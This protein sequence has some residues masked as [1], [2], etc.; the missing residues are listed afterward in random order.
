MR[1]LKVWLSTAG[2]PATIENSFISPPALPWLIFTTDDTYRGTDSENVIVERAVS[3]ELYTT[4]INPELEAQVEAL[5]TGIQ[6][7]K[8]REWI[9]SEKFFMCV[10][11]FDLIEKL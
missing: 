2:I 3:V 8:S 7:S 9:A 10:Y 5:F 1:D 4:K 11:D 6:F